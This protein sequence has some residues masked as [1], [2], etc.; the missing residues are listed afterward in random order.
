MKS[1]LDNVPFLKSESHTINEKLN[2]TN[3]S[4]K[5][6]VVLPDESGDTLWDEVLNQDK[7]NLPAKETE[8]NERRP[9]DIDDPIK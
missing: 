1:T 3:G 9:D 6:K 5:E 4:E 7:K 2:D 8:K